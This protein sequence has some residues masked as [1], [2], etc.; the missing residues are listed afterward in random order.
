MDSYDLIRIA[1]VKQA[2][3][4]YIVA[5]KKQDYKQRVKLERFF[6]GD[7]GQLLSDG[8]GEYIIEKCKKIAEKELTEFSENILPD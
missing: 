2:I 4:D 5:L 6:R 3:R 7:W 8:H 1:I